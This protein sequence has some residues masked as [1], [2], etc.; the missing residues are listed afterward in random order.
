MLRDFP[1]EDAAEQKEELKSFVMPA[2]NFP[3]RISP[4]AQDLILQLTQNDQDSRISI[5]DALQHP[6]FHQMLPFR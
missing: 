3:D 1:S 4:E 6:W 2:M 5:E